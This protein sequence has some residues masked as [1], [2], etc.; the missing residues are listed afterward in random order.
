MNQRKQ[1]KYVLNT[2]EA[3]RRYI[4]QFFEEVTNP[5]DF[6][7]SNTFYSIDGE[8]IRNEHVPLPLFVIRKGKRA[9]WFRAG[10]GAVIIKNQHLLE[11]DLLKDCFNTSVGLPDFFYEKESGVFHLV[12]FV[13]ENNTI[14]G[15]NAQSLHERCEFRGNCVGGLV[16]GLFDSDGREKFFDENDMIDGIEFLN[17]TFKNQS[18]SGKRIKKLI[19]VRATEKLSFIDCEIEETNFRFA[20]CPIVQFL[21]ETTINKIVDIYNVNSYGRLNEND[22]V[23]DIYF[24]EQADLN[25][26]NHTPE[27]KQ[28]FFRQI[29]LFQEKRGDRIQALFAHRRY[30]QQELKLERLQWWERWT[31]HVSKWFGG[32]LDLVKPLCILLLSFLFLSAITRSLNLSFLFPMFPHVMFSEIENVTILLG[33]LRP[34]KDFIFFIHYIVLVLSWYF[35]I[36]SLRKFTYRK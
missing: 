11:V 14:E 26:D 24:S 8:V 15:F 9:K 19:N 10:E 32:G 17:C 2:P 30:L 25:T 4:E 23:R 21:G 29:K 20:K 18:M 28:Y 6:L 3:V 5:I 33:C 36:K 1:K 22:G 31:I 16:S 27:E 35:I 34:L 12:K 13:F 7:R